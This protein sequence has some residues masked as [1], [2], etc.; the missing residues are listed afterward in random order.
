MMKDKGE[1]GYVFRISGMDENIVSV[2]IPTYN[3]AGSILAAVDSVLSQDCTGLEVLV[4][5]DGSQDETRS[6][7]DAYI[8]SAQIVYIHQENS[9]KPSRARNT[10]IRQAQ[11]RYLAFLDSDD[12][13][14]EGKLALCLDAL[15]EQKKAGLVFSDYI[16]AGEKASW[17]RSE[18]N[19]FLGA[20]QKKQQGGAPILLESK[21]I[22]R[23]LLVENCIGLST[24]V[25]D[26][27]KFEHFEFDTDLTIA[28]DLDL[29]LKLAGSS[30]IVYL[31]RP[32]VR[33][34]LHGD[35][36]MQRIEEYGNDLETVLNR[37]A[38]SGE[39]GKWAAQGLALYHEAASYQNRRL[40]RRGP[41]LRHA[42]KAA[43]LKPS[44]SSLRVLAAGLLAPS[45]KK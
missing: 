23:H 36:I 28:E 32:L 21:S 42:V 10:G 3:R 35:G 39:L 34:A 24:V 15:R 14:L 29:W 13:W 27:A 37:H 25:I 17:R 6:V 5:D 44:L 12:V 18:R 19:T 22:Q 43:V 20:L 26:R 41:A 30:D 11:G 7:L 16:I 1:Q 4:V 2:V 38:G 40:G 9:G 33:Y 45:T 8:R 31:P